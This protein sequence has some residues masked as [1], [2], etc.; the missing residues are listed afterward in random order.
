M[1]PTVTLLSHTIRPLE[2]LYACWEASRH[3]RPIETPNEIFSKACSTGD[4][5]ELLKAR[6]LFS[7]IM[8]AG[9]PVAENVSFTFLL[10]G[11][12][13]ALREQMVRHRIGVHFGDRLGVDI[14]PDLADSTWWAQSMR[15]LPME[16]FASEEAYDIPESIRDRPCTCLFGRRWGIRT[17]NGRWWTGNSFHHIAYHA[18]T[19]GSLQ[20][21][22]EHV[23]SNRKYLDNAAI[24]A[25]VG[26]PRYH[27]IE[28]PPSEVRD[29]VLR[30]CQCNRKI[31]VRGEP[32]TLEK[33]YREQMGW[34]QSAYNRLVEAGVPL[35]DARNLI[36]LA[37]TSR[38]TW[39]TN[40]AALKHILGKRGCWIL[41]LGVWEPII[42]G[43]VEELANK[44][45]PIF[46]TLI[47]PPCVNKGKYTGCKFELDNSRRIQG[48]DE[49][50]P[51][52]LFI[53]Q[54]PEHAQ[55][56]AAASSAAGHRGWV[57]LTIGGKFS[58]LVPSAD[59]RGRGPDESR[60]AAERSDAMRTAYGRLWGFDPDA[61]PAAQPAVAGSA[62][63]SSSR[64][65]GAP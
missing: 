56:H 9:I 8:D 50:P 51:C 48:E 28:L 25:S 19:W 33:F 30:H 60:R 58:G 46:R 24:S 26:D 62:Q 59:H 39:T 65:A 32:M 35:E 44:I 55:R 3:N 5:S 36:P 11:I 22:A 12:S 23:A 61:G 54:Q 21:A 34:I 42:R 13:I 63:G 45:D 29:R 57:P 7:Q 2:T 40:L 38:T 20:E 14:V 31:T 4:E 10:E 1:K 43:M 49:I 47:S 41:Q 52:R 16:R 27:A 15:I 37:A 64:P 53:S 18:Q 17:V 6:E